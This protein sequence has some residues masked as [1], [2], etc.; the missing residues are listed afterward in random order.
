VNALLRWPATFYPDPIGQSLIGAANWASTAVGAV[1]TIVL[2]AVYL[3]SV[4]ILHEQVN[5]LPPEEKAAADGAFGT[6]GFGEAGSQQ[7]GR[8]LQALAPLLTGLTL[9]AVSTL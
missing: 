5:W 8:L 7:F 2:L 3:P 9:T 1:F 6:M 4:S